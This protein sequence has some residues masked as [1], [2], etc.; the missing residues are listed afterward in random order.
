[1]LDFAAAFP[2]GLPYHE[3]LKRY[4]SDAHRRRWGTVYDR[5]QLKPEQLALLSG[6]KRQMKVLC[7]TGAWCKESTNQCPIFQRFVET[8]PSIE[9]RYF[10]RDE[11]P[12]LQAELRIC[13]GNR[14]PVVVFLSEDDKFLGLY[15][16]RTLAE[17]RQMAAE[18][19]G[20]ACTITHVPMQQ[21]LLDDITQHWLNEFERMQLMLRYSGRLRQLHGD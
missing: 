3:F 17:Y 14:I 13:G 21:T 10:D 6:F 12:D 1:M 9:I 18:P 8:A 15:G 2:Q 19:A 5:V 7:L 20:A 4:G 16:E 11:R